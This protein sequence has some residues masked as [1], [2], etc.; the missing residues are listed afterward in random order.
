VQRGHEELWRL[1]VF[2]DPAVFGLPGDFVAQLAGAI[3][4]SID[5]PNEIADFV[6]S[7]KVPIDT[8]FRE[9]SLSAKLKQ[10]G[11]DEKITYAH[12]VTL[13]DG[14]IAARGEGDPLIEQ[15]REWGY[16]EDNEARD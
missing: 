2:V 9:V 14:H 4:V 10:L 12:Y 6:I 11:V 15:L 7:R 1:E 5:V 13:V 8:L 16:L 3:E